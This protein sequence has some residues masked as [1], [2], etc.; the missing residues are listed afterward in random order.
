MNYDVVIGI[1]IHCELKTATK[2]FSGAPSAFGKSPNSCTNEVDLGHPGTLPSLNKKAV[3][4]AIMACTALNMSVDVLPA[5][6]SVLGRN[7]WHEHALFR[8]NDTSHL[9]EGKGYGIFD[10]K[11]EKK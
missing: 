11:Y 6:V 5:S 7:K 2:M 8:L 9:N 10:F 4:S 3:E 1:E